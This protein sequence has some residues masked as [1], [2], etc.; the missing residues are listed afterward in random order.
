MQVLTREEVLKGAKTLL[1]T[2]EEEA[3]EIFDSLDL[4]GSGTLEWAE[5]L[6]LE[7]VSCI[8]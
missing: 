8:F 5:I 7:K 6:E 1:H 4:D 2:S 3:S